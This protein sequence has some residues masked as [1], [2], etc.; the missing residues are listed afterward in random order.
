LWIFSVGIT[1]INCL[2]KR[3]HYPLVN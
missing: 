2:F 1:T 3:E